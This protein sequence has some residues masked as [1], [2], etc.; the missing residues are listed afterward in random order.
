MVVVGASGDLAKKKTYPCLFELYQHG[1]LPQQ[2]AIWG[3]ARTAKSHLDFRDHIHPHLTEVQNPKLAGPHK[4]VKHFLELCYYHNGESYGDEDAYQSMLKEITNEATFDAGDCNVLYYL[5]IPPNVFGETVN[6]LEKIPSAVVDG[7]TRFV[8]EKPFGNDTASCEALLEN[9]QG[10]GE[11]MQYRLDHYLAVSW[12][13]HSFHIAY[14]D[15]K[16][17]LCHPNENT[18][19]SHKNSC[20]LLFILIASETHG[21]KLGHAAHE[22]SLVGEHVV[23]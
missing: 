22:Q 5:A 9:F 7:K 10:L 20:C 11:A 1:L 21:G 4:T 13:M 23:S 15:F 14:L 19:N 16:L 3:Y 8:I 12:N 18:F 17:I 6:T 2:T